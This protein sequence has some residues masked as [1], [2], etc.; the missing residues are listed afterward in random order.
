MRIDFVE[1]GEEWWFDPK[2]GEYEYDGSSGLISRALEQLN[3]Y[4]VVSPRNTFGVTEHPGET[5]VDED[6]EDKADSVQTAIR[7][8]E[9]AE[10]SKAPT[11]IDLDEKSRWEELDDILLEA[12]QDQV[13][14]EN[15]SKL[16][17][18]DSDEV[19]EFVRTWVDDVVEMLD[20]MWTHGYEDISEAAAL[21]V[22]KE[23]TDSLTQPQGWSVNSIMRRLVNEFEWLDED[24][25][26]TITRNEVAAVLN[27]S[28]EVAYRARPDE[29]QV[30]WKGPDDESTTVICSEVKEEIESQGGSVEMSR[31]REIL[32]ETAS[33]HKDK[34]GTPE[35]VTQYV[36]HYQCRHTM[37]EV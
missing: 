36:P 8:T 6:P 16:M 17:W 2:T 23:I 3:D 30:R 34:G 11:V 37:I 25:A 20:P 29:V 19:P 22:H 27:R 31:L 9:S 35:R 26:R 21:T 33:R 1:D 24:Q 13:W 7:L 15:F 14:D 18:E 32:E 4:E 12:Y 10:L 5:W 28:R